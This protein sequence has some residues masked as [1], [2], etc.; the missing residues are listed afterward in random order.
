MKA[1]F[2]DKLI[3]RID[4]LD[5]EN[6]QSHFLRL[7]QERG[8]L[9]T[10]FESIQEGV[11]VVDGEGLIQYVNRA[12]ERLMGFSL[13]SA[14]GKKV[15]RYLR[16]VDWR[17]IMALDTDE[18]SRILSHEIEINYPEHRIL[19]F[20]VVP[21]SSCQGA[22][23]EEGVVVILRDVTNE[24][25]QEADLLESE[26]LNAVK[27]LAA[28]VAHEIGNPL[29]ALNI[30][31]QLLQREVKKL[32]EEQKDTLSDLVDVAKNEVSRLDLIITQF[33]RA[34]RPKEPD[35]QISG[36]DKLLEEVLTLLT[37]EMENRRIK[38][39]VEKPE[40][41]PRIKVDQNQI[42]QAFFNIIKNG[43]QAM[44]D[45]GR[46]KINVSVAD[47]SVV[48]AFRDTGKGINAE[49]MS[50]IFEPYYTNKSGGSGLGLM[51]VQRIIQD[52]GGQI[53]VASK[54]G[55]GTVFTVYLPLAERRVRLL[56]PPREDN[57][58]RMET[59]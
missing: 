46:L 12:V 11:I 29:N 44:P 45:G 5:P 52:H 4:R 23:Q 49:D 54:K 26:R 34:I 33:L 13:K 9:D 30:H 16:E 2:L 18:W 10:I 43:F 48:F 22:G 7:A 39:E 3:E 59:E 1:E 58:D 15:S 31:L 40:K 6:L 17:R 56:K 55:E 24:R 53:E 38:V 36:V 42:K 50:R 27:L 14:Q 37:Q 20:Y 41:I 32:P 8:L 51:I 25:E 57:H 19:N 35:F 21:L 28:G 47:N